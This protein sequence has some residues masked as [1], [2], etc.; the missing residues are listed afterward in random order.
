MLFFNPHDVGLRLVLGHPFLSC[1][2]VATVNRSSQGTQSQSPEATAALL[3][4][5]VML[6]EYR[7]CDRLRS[8]G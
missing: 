5:T 8:R 7:H 6:P 4:L 2:T 1:T 3:Y